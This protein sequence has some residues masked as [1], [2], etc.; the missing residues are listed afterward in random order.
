[1]TL[2]KKDDRPGILVVHEMADHPKIA[3]LSDA[4]FRLLIKAWS[5]CSRLETNG[6]I[7]DVVWR[8]MGSPKARRELTTPPALMPNHSPLIVQEAGYVEC[9]DYL[10]HQ[11]SSDEIDAIRTSRTLSGEKGAHMRWHVGRRIVVK[12]CGLCQEEQRGGLRDVR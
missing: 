1:M 7:P 4:A 11:R 8:G 3:P 9:H 10:A 6:R 5:Y 2:P 12:D